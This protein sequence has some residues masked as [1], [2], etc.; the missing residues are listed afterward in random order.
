MNIED[1]I[2]FKEIQ[3]QNKEVFEAIFYK[4]YPSL[5]KFSEK[6]VFDRVVG[7]D[8]IQS[9]FVFIWEH[10]PYLEIKSSLKSYLY[11]SVKNR[12]LNY[13][14]SKKIE[15]KYQLLFIEASLSDPSEINE[16]PELFYTLQEAINSLP[17]KMREI[18]RLKYEEEKTISE[19]SQI[20]QLSENT[21]KTQL[22]R[23]K[24]KL[25]I[26]LKES[27]GVNFFF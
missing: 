4:Y 14:R 7:E 9:L 6:I 24:S 26:L 23:A 25:R 21:V 12:C 20:L 16:E 3:K 15:D 1:K 8:I 11:I 5:L 10:A 17:T 22:L 18:F 2:V 13:L 19:I 27:I